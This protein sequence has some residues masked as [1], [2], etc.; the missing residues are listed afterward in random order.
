MTKRR[1][2]TFV[3]W[4]LAS[5]ILVAGI[6]MLPQKSIIA[7]T[8]SAILVSAAASL[9]DSLTEIRQSYQKVKTNITINHNF[10]ASGTLLQQIVNG[11]PADVFISAAQKQMNELQQKNLILPETRRNLL[12]NTVVLI[13]PKSSNKV[14]KFRGLTSANVKRIA[15]GEPRSV[16]VG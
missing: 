3:G 15:V 14:T 12:T 13:V 4:I 8:N 10:G 9:K 16:P 7:E 5:L 1:I 6:R 2:I 11:A